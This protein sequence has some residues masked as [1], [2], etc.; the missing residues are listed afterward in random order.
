LF[1]P[2]AVSRT[3]DAILRCSRSQ[4]TAAS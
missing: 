1:S 4:A 3:F 2:R